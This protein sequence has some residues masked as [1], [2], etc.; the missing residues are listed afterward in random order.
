MWLPWVG[1]GNVYTS[2]PFALRITMEI[3]VIDFEFNLMNDNL[4]FTTGKGYIIGC[5]KMNN[6]HF[7]L[8]QNLD[9]HQ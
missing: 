3:L 2:P 1:V 8:T 9:R 6:R 7:V 5:Y 4:S